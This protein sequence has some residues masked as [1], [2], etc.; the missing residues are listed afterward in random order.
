MVDLELE[1]SQADRSLYSVRGTGTLRF[2]GF[3]SRAA[4]AD[5]GETSRRLQCRGFWRRVAEATDDGGA[6]IGSFEPRGMRRG[7]TVRWSG[8]ELALRSASAWRERYAL[9]EGDEELAVFDG[10]GWGRKP[11]AIS[12]SAP[13]ALDPGLVLFTA[14]VVRGLAVAASA[15]AGSSASVAATG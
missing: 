15:V 9:V 13:G 2:G 6:I 5:A 4:V 11:V 12:V 7:G 1:R 10:K 3:L 8:R 14:F